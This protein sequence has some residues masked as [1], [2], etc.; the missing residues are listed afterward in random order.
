[1]SLDES[2]NDS[3]QVSNDS[4]IATDDASWYE[5]GSKP[6]IEKTLISA[7]CSPFGIVASRS[8]TAPSTPASTLSWKGG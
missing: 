5:V 2:P 3:G 4:G 6:F 1:M 7:G 8:F